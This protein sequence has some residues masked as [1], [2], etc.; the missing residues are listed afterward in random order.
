MKGKIVLAGGTG[1]IGKA[2]ISNL[3]DEFENIVVLSRHPQTDRDHIRYV[4]WDGKTVG[5][6]KSELDGADVLINLAGKN[7]NCRY[8]LANRKEILNSRIN[9]VKVLADAIREC[10][11]PPEVWI[12]S[13]SATI[14]R[15]SLD[16]PMDEFIH[17]YGTGFSVDVCKAWEGTFWEETKEFPAM[18]KVILRIS[19]VLSKDDGVLPR[20]VTMTKLGLGGKQGPGTQMVSWIHEE[21][22][23]N[24]IKW[25]IQH[26]EKAGVY[27]CT[28]PEV[29]S[30]AELMKKLR[31]KLNVLIG[32]PSG[33]LLLEIGA[34]IIRTET[35]LILKS[36]LVLPSRLL[37]E[38]YPFKFEKLEK[39]L[40][41]LVKRD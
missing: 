20:L 22:L 35:E 19:M 27:N 12:Q 23:V 37:W 17:E 24:I 1:Q 40:N 16:K 41:D 9:S 3:K 32:I 11:I 4:K 15:H 31:N 25:I 21:D 39:A 14:Y 28:S 33:K 10:T 6:W 34:F 26:I 2:I 38:K 18:R 5:S 36:R 7:V 13:A 8:T 30:N 29:I